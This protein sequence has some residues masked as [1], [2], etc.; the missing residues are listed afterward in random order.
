MKEQRSSN[1]IQGLTLLVLVVNLVLAVSILAPGHF[2]LRN[3]TESLDMEAA[4]SPYTVDAPIPHM[5]L[6]W[7]SVDQFLDGDWRVE[8]F[9]E[10]EIYLSPDGEILRE[11]PTAHYNY[12]RYWRYEK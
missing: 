7:R 6:E 8:K 1:K 5:Q 12:L 4:T 11:I 3:I 2:D 9:Q 10:Y